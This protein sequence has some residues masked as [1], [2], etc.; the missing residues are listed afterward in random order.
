MPDNNKHVGDENIKM[1][2]TGKCHNV[3]GM[4]ILESSRKGI[5]KSNPERSFVQVDIDMQQ[6][7]LG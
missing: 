5:I 1:I 7:R 4:L 2:Y 3:Y 6:L